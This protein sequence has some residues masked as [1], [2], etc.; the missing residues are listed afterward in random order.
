MRAAVVVSFLL[1]SPAWAEVADKVPSTVN[2][3]GW[4]LCF[5]ALAFAWCRSRWWLGV[6]VAVL[7]LAWSAASASELHAPDLGPAIVAE[8][9]QGHVVAAW[10]AFVG[11]VVGPLVMAVLARLRTARRAAAPRA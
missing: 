5:N 1:A 6:V 7:A 10:C 9:G 2:Y 4:A 3:L 8:L 11:S